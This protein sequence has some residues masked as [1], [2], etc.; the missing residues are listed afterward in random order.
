[1]N[2]TTSDNLVN[3]AVVNIIRGKAIVNPALKFIGF[4]AFSIIS[5]IPLVNLN[6]SY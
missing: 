6:C 4:F 3:Y 1:L 5:L 2:S